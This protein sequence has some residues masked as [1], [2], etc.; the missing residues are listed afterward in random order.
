MWDSP[1]QDTS[2]ASKGPGPKV[3]PGVVSRIVASQKPRLRN[4]M[5]R[6][7]T[8]FPFLR[9]LLLPAGAFEAGIRS[10]FNLDKERVLAH[11]SL[12]QFGGH[13]SKG[14]YGV[15]HGR[16]EEAEAIAAE[17]HG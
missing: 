12:P 5:T 1:A 14:G 13:R 4:P 2:W 17:L 7:A 8:L 10:G 11:L 16:G 6:E 9:W 15:E 3:I